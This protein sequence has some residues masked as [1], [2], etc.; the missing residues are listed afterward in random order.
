MKMST[1]PGHSRAAV[2]HAVGVPLT[3]EDFPLRKPNGSEAV[4]RVKCATVCGSDLHSFYGRRH[5]PIPSVLGHEMVGE[6]VAYGPEGA[7]D[8]RGRALEIG[9]RVTWSMVWS[10]GECFYCLA[11]PAT[12]V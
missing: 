12:K 9:D 6:I 3:L 10:C 2:F 7:R 11:G 5:S 8:F 4:A 1:L